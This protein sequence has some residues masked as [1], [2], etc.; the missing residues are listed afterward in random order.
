MRVTLNF[1]PNFSKFP[2]L[3]SSQQLREGMI[4]IDKYLQKRTVLSISSTHIWLSHKSG[5]NKGRTNQF[6]GKEHPL[7]LFMRKY[8]NWIFQ[9]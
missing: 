8:K 3:R 1:R 6:V 9:K 7:D 2:L 5:R 4:L